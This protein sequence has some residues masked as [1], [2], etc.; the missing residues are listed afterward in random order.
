MIMALDGRNRPLAT[1]RLGRASLADAYAPQRLN[2]EL[3]AD[4]KGGARG[5]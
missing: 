4:G 1:N 3:I 2:A 5:P